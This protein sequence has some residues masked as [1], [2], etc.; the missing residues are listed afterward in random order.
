M[1]CCA[2]LPSADGVFAWFSP[3]FARFRP[4]FQ[5]SLD[6]DYV[7]SY[8][9]LSQDL[10]LTVPYTSAARGLE[11]R[12]KKIFFRAEVTRSNGCIVSFGFQMRE[13]NSQK[14]KPD[15]KN[16]RKFPFFLR[17]LGFSSVLDR[18]EKRSAYGRAC[19]AIADRLH[20][21][22]IAHRLHMFSNVFYFELIFWAHLKGCR[23]IVSR[24]TVWG[25][26]GV[27]D[28]EKCGFSRLS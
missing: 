28:S 22:T 19:S 20:R 5:F 26:G 18:F 14:S 10:V 2:S 25:R 4:F 17:I 12:A 15:S 24:S 3:V 16:F 11:G 13:S 23:L 21:Y 27:W 6:A 9:P 7:S 8:D 1:L